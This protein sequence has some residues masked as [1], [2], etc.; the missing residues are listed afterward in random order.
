MAQR[1]RE[2]LNYA[3]SG[4]TDYHMRSHMNLH[5]VE[6]TGMDPADLLEFFSFKIKAKE[7]KEIMR[8]IGE[9]LM[10]NKES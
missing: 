3:T 5:E 10:I 8:Q 9:A 7:P 4:E 1:L 2:H 6:T